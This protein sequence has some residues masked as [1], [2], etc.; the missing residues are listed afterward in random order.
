MSKIRVNAT[1]PK[2]PLLVT[3]PMDFAFQA[4]RVVTLLIF[5]MQVL[6]IQFTFGV[7]P[8]FSFTRPTETPHEKESNKSRPKKMSF[9]KENKTKFQQN[10]IQFN[11]HKCQVKQTNQR[12]QT[13][14]VKAS[15]TKF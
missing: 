1:G 3:Q 8:C 12:K 14:N 4:S 11:G 2:P 10:K 15:S 7:S 5:R 9:K 13:K 6:T